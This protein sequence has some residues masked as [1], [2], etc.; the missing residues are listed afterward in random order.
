M[1]KRNPGRWPPIEK[2]LFGRVVWTDRDCWEWAGCQNGTGYGVIGWQGRQDLT[3]RVSYQLLVG[4]IPAG[5]HI[6]HLCRNRLCIN[7]SHL[8]PVTCAENIARGLGAKRTVCPRGHVGH[9]VTKTR[10]KGWPHQVC[11]ECRRQQD[12]LR[13]P[14]RRAAALER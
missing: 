9:Y 2:R 11:M 14:A 6:D 4:P 7:P 8:E 13:Y 10:K 12:R 1:G 3:H 5:L